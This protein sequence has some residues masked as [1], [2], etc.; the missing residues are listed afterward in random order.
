M[1]VLNEVEETGRNY[2][3]LSA[4][5]GRRSY[6]HERIEPVQ[7]AFECLDRLPVM[8][9]TI[10]GLDLLLREPAIDLQGVSE[11]ILG[12]I[13]ATIH[14]LRTV[15]KEYDLAEVPSVRIGDCLASLDSR[16]CFDLLSAHALPGDSGR[17]MT[18]AFWRHSRVVALYSKQIAASTIGMWPEEA[19]LVGLLHEVDALPAVLELV[20]RG[21]G[22]NAQ[23]VRRALD[24]ILP[25][26][27]A[28][29]IRRGNDVKTPSA[30]RTLLSAA[31]QLAGPWSGPSGQ[32]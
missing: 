5:A 19:Y 15:S 18:T 29:G 8:S 4:Q 31:H 17:S 1:A 13:G 7:S 23:E 28:T 11:L 3:W 27:I 14:I 16:A 22:V 6:P 20:G 12:D 32:L 10:L 30:W 26:A 9:A 25:V 2:G 21:P 24:G